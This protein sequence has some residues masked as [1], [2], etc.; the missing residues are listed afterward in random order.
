M[1]FV[2]A[3]KSEYLENRQIDPLQMLSDLRPDTVRFLNQEPGYKSTNGGTTGPGVI[4]S[5]E[6]WMSCEGSGAVGTIVEF[7]LTEIQHYSQT[8]QDLK[9]RKDCPIDRKNHPGPFCLW[10]PMDS[11]RTF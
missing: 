3:R 5:L 2:A 11:R 6:C 10:A 7:I 1:N 9:G 4:C 8:Y